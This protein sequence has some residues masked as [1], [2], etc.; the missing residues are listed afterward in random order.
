MADELGL[1]ACGGSDY[2]ASG[3]PGEARPGDV[4]PPVS[5]VEALRAARADLAGR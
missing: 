3:N 1:I 2:H 4:G 5:S